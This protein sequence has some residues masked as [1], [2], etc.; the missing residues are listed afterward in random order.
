MNNP[1][2]GWLPLVVFLLLAIAGT[3]AGILQSQT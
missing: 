2:L 3:I 1:I